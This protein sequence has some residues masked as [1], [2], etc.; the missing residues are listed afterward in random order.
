MPRAERV[1]LIKQIEEHRKSRVLSFVLGDRQNLN[2]I[3]A[4]DAVRVIYNHMASIGKTER[5]DVFLYTRGGI[6]N[7]PARIV[8]LIREYTNELNVLVPY[9]CHSGGTVLSCGANN[10]IMHEMGELSPVD[11]TT[12]YPFNPTDRQGRSLP[13]GVEDVRGYLALAKSWGLESEASSVEALKLLSSQINVLALGNIQRVYNTGA[14]LMP[15]LLELHMDGNKDKERIKTILHA[16]GE[17]YT[18]DYLIPRKEAKALGLPVTEAAGE[19]NTLIWNLYKLYE[20]DLQLL[21]SFVPALPLDQNSSDFRFETAYVE[22]TDRTDAFVQEGTI[23]RSTP[24]PQPTPM[25]F[26]LPGMPQPVVPP[27]AIPG[28]PVVR[29]RRQAWI[30]VRE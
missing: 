9:R 21:T 30:E 8:H 11:S 10:I 24:Q 14:N 20:Q 12:T 19:L 16:L 18:H 17:T 26:G 22:T 23:T 7:A 2:T 13:I 29:F 1:S 3:I 15:D 4:D 5:V 27:P 28:L 25:P 6:G